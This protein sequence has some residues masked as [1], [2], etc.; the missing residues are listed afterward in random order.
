MAIVPLC[1][2]VEG[3]EADFYALLVKKEVKQTTVGSPYFSVTFR[4]S[5]RTV[6]FPI[7]NDSPLTPQAQQW[8]PGEYFKIRGVYLLSKYGAQINIVKIRLV[9]EKDRQ[10]GFDEKLFVGHSQFDPEEMFDEILNIL[11]Q[12]IGA[13]DS[14]YKLCQT[15]LTENKEVLLSLS[16][17]SHNHHAFVGGWLEHTRNV[18]KN[19]IMLAQRYAELYPDLKPRLDVGL[20]AAGAALHDI[21]KLEEIAFTGA[22][23]EYTSQ[24]MLIGHM[25]QG[26]D[27]VRDACKRLELTGERFTLLEHIIIA[28][29]RLPEWGAPKPPMIAEALLVHYADDVDAKFAIITNVEKELSPG[30][31][32]P[33]KNT[34]G[35]KVYRPEE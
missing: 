23:F 21:G 12:V 28:H 9:E 31:F 14:L 7:W 10:N 18:L 15:I 13:E 33:T 27:I 26:R 19:A 20:V 17:A 34:M 29:Q 1:E 30:T 8:K 25:L 2:L 32:S 35:Y 4:D 6:T 3:Q 16:A 22:G 11:E 5:S 24:G